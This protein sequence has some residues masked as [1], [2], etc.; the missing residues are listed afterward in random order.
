MTALKRSLTLKDG[1]ALGIG[2]I[3]GS[4]VLFLPSFTY[5]IAGSSV[6]ISWLL[7]TCLCL[8]LLF[9]FRDMIEAVPN[10]E[11]LKGFVALGLG[12]R[13]AAAIPILILGTVSIGMPSAAIIAG[14]YFK[15]VV[16]TAL[17]V[18]LIFAFLLLVAAIAINA[19]GV[20][21]SSAV[22]QGVAYLLFFLGA[23]IFAVSLPLASGHYTQSLA[24]DWNIQ[25]I[26][27]GAVISFWAFAGFENMT[28]TAGE[29]KNPKRDITLSILIA[30]VLCGMLYI[31]LTAN[32]AALMNPEA[33]DKTTGLFVM[34][35]NLPNQKLL[36]GAIALFAAGAVFINLTSW[37]W[38][39][40]RL[41]Y[42]SGKN[43]ELPSYFGVLSQKRN[44]QR[45]LCLLLALFT[46]SLSLA[47]FLPEFFELG[48]KIVSVNFVFLYLIAAVAYARIANHP[49]KRGLGMLISV[50]L[51][52]SLFNFSW[53]VC[54]PTVLCLGAC[55]FH[56]LNFEKL[57]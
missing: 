8:P 29:F 47:Y 4:G 3:M 55:L 5:S 40:S 42:S 33:S 25:K 34:V 18:E 51:I 38:G 52:V 28:F 15:H 19:L 30:L 21:F 9:L 31:G 32:Y 49:L 27:S 35:S 26:V 7:S 14:N 16:G 44:P 2:S 10:E 37:S 17:P 53:L 54:Y 6:L 41:I 22:N 39:L 11:G 36:E 56:K 13:A 48:L 43:R 12:T 46:V 57:K 24:P 20:H 50:A 1:I 45:A 23:G